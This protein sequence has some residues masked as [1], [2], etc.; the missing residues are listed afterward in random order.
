MS[1]ITPF[2]GKNEIKIDQPMKIPSKKKSLKKCRLIN[3]NETI[4]FGKKKIK[5]I[6]KQP[7]IACEITD[8]FTENQVLVTLE[9]QLWYPNY[10]KMREEII[11]QCKIKGEIPIKQC[12]SRDYI[13]EN[14]LIGTDT[15][16]FDTKNATHFRTRY[17]ANLIDKLYP[18]NKDENGNFINRF[19][20]RAVHYKL[21]SENI[22]FPTFTKHNGWQLSKYVGSSTQWDNLKEG[23]T[24][25]RNAGLIPFDMMVDRRVPFE[26]KP[27]SYVVSKARQDIFEPSMNLDLKLNEDFSLDIE[28]PQIILYSEK[29][30]MGYV[31]EKLAEKYANIGYFL[32]R[33][34]I[35][36]S[37]ASELY[38][39]IKKHGE[40]AIILALND[41]DNSGLNISQSLARKLQ[42]H[43]Q[44]DKSENK[45]KIT[46]HQF[47]ISPKD[48]E[49][50]EKKG[51]EMGI[52]VYK[53]GDEKTAKK[54]YELAALDILA[55]DE[56]ISIT[57]WFDKELRK[58]IK[59]DPDCLECSTLIS[60]DQIKQKREQ[61][62]AKL[63]TE[64]EQSLNSNLETH[65]ITEKIVDELRLTSKA[66][67]SFDLDD[68]L[69][70]LNHYITSLPSYKILKSSVEATEFQPDDIIK[71]TLDFVDEQTIKNEFLLWYEENDSYKKATERL[72]KFKTETK[73]IIKFADPEEQRKKET[74]QKL[75][76]H[77][78]HTESDEEL[79][80]AIL[81]IL[82][83]NDRVESYHVIA[84][85]LNKDEEKPRN[86]YVGQGG[87][88]SRVMKQLK[89]SGKISFLPF[90]VNQRKKGWYLGKIT[91]PIY[92][93]SLKIPKFG[94]VQE[95]NA[96]ELKH[97]GS[98]KARKEILM[99]EA[100]KMYKSKNPETNKIWTLE[101][102]GEKLGGY[103]QTAVYKLLRESGIDTKRPKI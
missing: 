47:A 44:R 39:F 14:L 72:L 87:Q 94:S 4:F 89:H 22:G 6:G 81:N 71:D 15:D 58:I 103:G 84:T 2:N 83:P 19:H 52:K 50:F 98:K 25:S 77:L 97:Y 56:G 40:N 61:E 78:S 79:A 65:P 88:L 73:D 82:D 68:Y 21:L 5:N 43:V 7:T 49:E 101:E 13:S 69:D 51:I 32:G 28:V 54:I 10:S 1:D 75:D 100:V 23:L 16:S 80:E 33:G 46:V 63:K 60:H 31:L 3:S 76:L 24:E 91:I 93:S 62:E 35:S 9:K 17:I 66:N 26:V 96:W 42:Y 64:I 99:N 74:E 55:Y 36:T 70:S 45:P 102:I 95:R 86:L 48:A 41:F 11:N 30:E 53:G 85:I 29:S 8:E 57:D 59:H 37:N 92:E 20:A 90:E 67:G 34:Q 18:K 27:S 12:E 38:Q